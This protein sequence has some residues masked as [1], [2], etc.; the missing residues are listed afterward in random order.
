MGYGQTGQQAYGQPDYS[1][2]GY[3]APWQQP[4]PPP[5]DGFSIAALVLGIVPIFPLAFIFGIV[6]I[7]RTKNKQRR[8]RGLAIAG[9]ILSILWG[10]GIIVAIVLAA[11]GAIGPNHVDRNAN[12]DVSHQQRVSP[13]AL[14]QGDCLQTPSA[15]STEV[16]LITVMPCSVLHNGQDIGEVTLPK[17]SYPGRD[18]M[19]NEAKPECDAKAVALL[20]TGHSDLS[21]YVFYPNEHRW[22]ILGDRTLHCIVYDPNGQFT[23]DITAHK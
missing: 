10:I 4:L 23:G 7:V 2:P 21:E 19:L 15:T 5:M 8:G 18:Q 11:T 12:G 1:Q 17:G 16:N 13:T 22:T 6:G 20:G 9:L 3:G 14:K